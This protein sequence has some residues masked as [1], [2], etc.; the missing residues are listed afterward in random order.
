MNLSHRLLGGY[1]PVLSNRTFL[2]LWLAQLVSSFGDA[3][4]RVAILYLVTELTN[5]PLALTAVVIAQM[6]PAVLLAPLAGVWVDRLDKKRLLVTNDLL[7]FLV[8]LGVTLSRDLA[9]LVC[10]SALLSLSTSIYQPAKTT[11]LPAVVG[12]EHFVSA[13]SLSQTTIQS[14]SLIGPGVAGAIIAV[15]ETLNPGG[16]SGA[17]LVFAVNAFT[18]A[19]SGL[20]ILLAP[21]PRLHSAAANSRFCQE[22]KAGAAYIFST[23]LLSFLSVL[24]S[25]SVLTMGGISVLMTDYIRNV[26][27]ASPL[28]YGFVQ[29]IIAMGTLISLTAVGYWGKRAP[30]LNVL[31]AA[32]AGFG[33]A[34][35]LF[36]FSPGIAAV[37]VWALLI[38]LS[39]GATDG[40]FVGL[41]VRNTPVE[42]RGRVMTFF[43]SFMRFTALAGMG[44]AGIFADL[45]GSGMVLAGC[46]A[47]MLATVAVASTTNTWRSL[48]A[49]GDF[50]D[51]GVHAA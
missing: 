44:L 45:A 38:G 51:E 50:A 5:S 36:F 27:A 9:A 13:A 22:F 37:M 16:L 20:I 32:L 23:P 30:L 3:A 41:F 17:Q 7:R 12:E 34:N 2:S 33:L 26:L 14:M 6:L 18:F 42:K 31:M 21:L 29:S 40:P 11:L 25:V 39:D 15:G 48:K 19:L 1:A 4:Y 43:T 10:F 47:F 24:L 8:L 35:L 49:K 28:Q 46:G